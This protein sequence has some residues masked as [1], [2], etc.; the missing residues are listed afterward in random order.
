MY[1]SEM[2][3][4]DILKMMVFKLIA[5]FY[6]VIATLTKTYLYLLDNVDNTDKPYYCL[7]EEEKFE[8]GQPSVYSEEL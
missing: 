7:T 4:N 2:T 1:D 3:W 6:K 5:F 8:R